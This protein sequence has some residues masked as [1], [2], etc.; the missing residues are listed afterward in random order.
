[1]AGEPTSGPLAVSPIS[2]SRAAPGRNVRPAR[3]CADIGPPGRRRTV[4]GPISARGTY[5]GAGVARVRTPPRGVHASSRRGSSGAL[6]HGPR[7]RRSG[8]APR[9]QPALGEDRTRRKAT[10]V[11][12]LVHPQPP[13]DTPALRRKRPTARAIP[14]P[15]GRHI[16]HSTGVAR[17]ALQRGRLIL[18]PY[19][20][21]RPAPQPY[22]AHP[23]HHPRQAHLPLRPRPERPAVQPG[24]AHPVLRPRPVRPAPESR[25]ARSLPLT[26]SEEPPRPRLA[27]VASPTPG[28]CPARPIPRRARP[29]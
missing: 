7:T 26:A 18:H 21:V 22:P 5:L 17:P 16:P 29:P 19:R 20:T 28:P 23:P 24:P 13:I 15:R 4:R 25:W 9:R 11:Y 27:P 2:L 10:W 14:P 6:S 3:G 12:V 8:R 1:M